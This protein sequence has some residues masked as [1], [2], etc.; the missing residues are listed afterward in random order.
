[1]II[2]I[3]KYSGILERPIFAELSGESKK[4]VFP[5]IL[6]ILQA[7]EL[8]QQVDYLHEDEAILQDVLSVL[9]SGYAFDEA[10]RQMAQKRSRAFWLIDL[11]EPIRRLV[12]W[13]RQY[14]AKVRFLYRLSANTDAVLLRVL[15]RLERTGVIVQ[16]NWDL[17][18]MSS[19]CQS[20]ALY[21]DTMSTNDSSC[22]ETIIILQL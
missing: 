1:M 11:A 2:G 15:E 3:S 21:D 12:Q 5:S 20:P 9:P 18:Q 8:A 19:S 14:P 7:H 16:T 13:K 4:Q 6:P 22:S 17:S 10:I